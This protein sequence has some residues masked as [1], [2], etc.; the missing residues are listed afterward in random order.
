MCENHWNLTSII[1]QVV[2]ESGALDIGH[3]QY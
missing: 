2:P 1:L 3:I